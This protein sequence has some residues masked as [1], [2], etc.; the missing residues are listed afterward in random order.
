MFRRLFVVSLALAA[1]GCA[2]GGFG[3]GLEPPE[4]TLADIEFVGAGLFEQ[5]L[6][7]VL[8]MRNPN[9]EDLPIDGLRVRLE[10]DDKPFASGMSNEDVTIPGLGEETV[11]VEAVSATT[12]V[13][14]QLRRMTGFQDIDYA[15][16]GTAFLSGSGERRLPFEQDGTVRLSGLGQ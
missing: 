1:A 13:L 11:T 5:R 12:D 9:K 16:A 6:G 3:G 10:I 8:R 7:L 14:N 15:I 2:G 4:V